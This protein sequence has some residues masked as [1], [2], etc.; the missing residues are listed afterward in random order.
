MSR[1]IS[2]SERSCNHGRGSHPRLRLLLALLIA[3]AT[4]AS[5][6]EGQ[7]PGRIGARSGALQPWHAESYRSDLYRPQQPPMPVSL[8]RAT[9]RGQDRTPTP[10]APIIS[11]AV[12]GAGQLLTGR[13]RGSIYLVAEAF[14][15]TRYFSLRQEAHRER[16]RFLDLSFRVARRAF[17]P[18]RRDTAFQYFEQMER[19]IESGPFDLDPGPGFL[20][21][22][23]ERTFN[24][25]V[26][27]LARQ[28][29]FANADSTPPEDS[30]EYQRAIEFYRQR[31]VGPSY[32][33]SWRNA[34]LEQDLFR[35]S[36]RQSDRA[37]RRATQQLGLLLANHLLSAIDAF[38]SYR[39]TLNGRPLTMRSALFHLGE[40]RNSPWMFLGLGWRF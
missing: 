18:V 1:S 39:L 14:L 26:W 31:A 17:Q 12:P 40:N 5:S 35:Q 10:L 8:D 33:W 25:S 2:V 34:G 28:T 27:A 16:E 19:F 9:E 23:D 24:G 37:F 21:A 11:A 6:L 29:F 3:A 38:V 22:T 36:I 32:Q 13:E 15:V 7:T 30:P 4:L 20:P